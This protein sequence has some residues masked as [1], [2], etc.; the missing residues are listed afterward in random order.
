M[1]TNI[2]TCVCER[3]LIFDLPLSP[4]HTPQTTQLLLGFCM[5]VFVYPWW[6]TGLTVAAAAALL[7]YLVRPSLEDQSSPSHRLPPDQ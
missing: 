4:A 7:L 3:R 1:E 5:A 2:H 6:A